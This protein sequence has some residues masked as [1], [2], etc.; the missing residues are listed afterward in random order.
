MAQ[1]NIGSCLCGS[2]KFELEGSLES[3]FLCHCKYC[4]KD[5]GSAFAA[6]AFSTSA[7]LKWISNESFV[8]TFNLPDTRHV[9]SFCVNCGCALPSVQNNGKM[10]VVPVGSLDN[11]LE[12]KPNAHLFISSKA[13]WENDLE[14]VQAFEKFPS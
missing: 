12:I 9:K 4:Q 14:S 2:V 11:A 6:N 10:I 5:T 13:N 8:K 7:K 1:K 3:F